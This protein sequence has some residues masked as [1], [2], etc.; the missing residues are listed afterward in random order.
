MRESVSGHAL[1]KKLKYVE[2]ILNIFNF[3]G[4]QEIAEF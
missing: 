4:V 1:L 3:S 2:V